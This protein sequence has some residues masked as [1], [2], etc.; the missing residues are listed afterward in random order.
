[1]LK[2]KKEGG[3]EEEVELGLTVL[4]CLEDVVKIVFMEEL[5]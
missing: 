1:M 5:F 4:A 2:L 3:G